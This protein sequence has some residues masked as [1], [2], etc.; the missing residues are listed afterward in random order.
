L[1]RLLLAN[2]PEYKEPANWI[3]LAALQLNPNGK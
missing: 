3:N 2:L 1:R